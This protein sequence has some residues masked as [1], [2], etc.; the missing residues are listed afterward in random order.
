MLFFLSNRF[1]SEHHHYLHIIFFL[2]SIAL[3]NSCKMQFALLA[4]GKYYNIEIPSI[5]FARGAEAREVVEIVSNFSHFCEICLV[6]IQQA[7]DDDS[8]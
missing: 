2:R 7:V 6:A 8:S 4:L 3:T 5:H 1:V